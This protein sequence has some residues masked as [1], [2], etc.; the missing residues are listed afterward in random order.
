MKIT[1]CSSSNDI[2][3][4][5]YKESSQHL[6]DYLVKIKNSELNWGSCSISIMG[7]CYNTFKENSKKINGY[8]T[9]KYEEDIRNLPNATHTI[10]DTTF[11]LKK[12]IFNDADII[13]CLPGGTGTIS[14]FFAYLEEI[15]S[16]DINKM[17]ILYDEN[18][19]F[20][21]TL[22]LIDDLIE[23]NFNNKSIY[24]YFKIAHN[25]DE[26]KKIIKNI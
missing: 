3:D 10:C 1:I 8:T 5:K 14:E 9:K 13:I 26:L 19:H 2:I 24:N 21:T 16:N 20:D 7:Q 4:E 15:R 22:K 23:R 6:L 18:H 17:L 11:D 12:N 25:I